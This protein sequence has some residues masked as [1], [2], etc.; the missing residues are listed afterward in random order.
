MIKKS[1]FPTY[2]VD[3]NI[4][5]RF[6][7]RENVFG[8][9]LLD[10]KAPFYRRS[11]YEN[12][13]DILKRNKDGYSRMEFAR[14][15]GGWTVYDYFHK[16]FTW[17]SRDEA[18]SVMIKPYL[19]KMK[20]K[21]PAYMAKKV[22]ES[23]RLYGADIVGI[24]K[25]DRRWIYSFDIAGNPISIPDR[26]SYCIVLAIA[27]DK[28]A[29]KN[30]PLFQATTATA[31]GY[32][33]VAFTIACLSEFIRYLGYDAYPM[34][35]DTAI[36]IPLAIDSG[37]GELGRNGLLITPQYGACVRLGKIF[38]DLPLQIDK[39]IEFGVTDYCSKCNICAD[40]CEPNAI[41]KTK[42]PSL[43]IKCPSNNRGIYRWAVNH[44]RCYSF[45]IENGGDCSN[46]IS[47]CPYTNNE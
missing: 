24:C 12:V 16:A 26:L 38:T 46:C 43:K 7:E 27:M 18:N 21:D 11:M 13:P 35:N 47:S 33:K 39:C 1:D 19:E 6:D 15:I 28:D 3:D 14:T 22:K 34:G 31:I 40:V 10:R 20:V 45:W 23:G 44:D 37:L 42:E 25:V 8:R 17:E 41:Q 9:M 30:S 5:K 2:K 4:L 32:S 29:I 36:S